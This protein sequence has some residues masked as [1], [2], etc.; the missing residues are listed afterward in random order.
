MRRI[1]NTSSGQTTAQS[2]FPSQ[3]AKLTDGAMTPGA[4]LQ[5]V[6]DSG[7]MD[8]SSGLGAKPA[9]LAGPYRCRRFRMENIVLRGGREPEFYVSGTP[10]ASLTRGRPWRT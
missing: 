5:A 6:V 10:A 1:S 7:V 4:C 2:A 8:R 3:R 9:W